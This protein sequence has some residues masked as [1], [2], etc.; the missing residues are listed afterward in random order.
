MNCTKGVCDSPTHCKFTGRCAESVTSCNGD[1]DQGRKCDCTKT[2][3]RTNTELAELADFLDLEADKITCYAST[4]PEYPPNGAA[5]L[6]HEVAKIL[7][8]YKAK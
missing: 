1:C 3:V 2:P 7:R 5:K 4:I 6:M 8:E